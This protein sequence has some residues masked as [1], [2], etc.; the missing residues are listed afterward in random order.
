[1]PATLAQPL[2]RAAQVNGNG[3]ATICGERQRT[4]REVRQ[5]V[6]QLAGALADLGI[7]EGERIG[8]L[9]WNSDRYFELNFAIPWLGA[10]LVPLNTRLETAELDYMLRD[11]GVSALC[12]DANGAA[13]VA[14]LAATSA[15]LRAVIALD[16]NVPA[17]MLDYETLVRNGAPREDGARG[18]DQL[19]G[20]FYT[21]G[22]SGQAKGVML[23]HDNLIA[24][25]S[26]VIPQVGYD[27]NSVYL[28]AA[29]MFHLA[30]GMAIYALTTVGGTHVF[31]PHFDAAACLDLLARHRVTNIALVPTMVEL[32]VREAERAPRDLSALR[33][34]QFGAAPMPDGT[35][36]RLV[37]L[38]PELLL[39]H[40]WGMTEL[41]PVGTML[42][43]HW[44]RPA[45]AGDRLRSCGTAALNLELRIV[46]PDGR[47]LPPGEVGEI[48][49]RGPVVMLGYWNKPEETAAALRDGWLHTG[50]LAWLD[51]E[52]LVYIVDRLKDM[53]ITGGEN[54]FSSE[55][56]NVLSQQPGVAAVAVIGLPDP[57]YGEAVHAVVV[58]EP[59]ATLDGAAL[60]AACRGHI[61]GYKCPR[62]VTIRTEP[63][64]LS[65]TGKILKRVLREQYRPSP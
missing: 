53:I 25:A 9:A 38:W 14:P 55:V 4:W 35:L 42:P 50:D 59:G 64:P 39:L 3:I 56:E 30:D 45:V 12:V 31:M 63:L 1:M 27:G 60:I 2:H 13:R 15:G 10:V 43:W 62:S 7:R 41:A 33:Q 11:A 26:N 6:M 51:D 20:I 48:V 47:E 28:H 61:A 22:N 44:R 5:R 49:M 29:P 23:S 65:G 58:P 34:I 54:V 32:I 19:A 24:N 8:L 16:D 40:G 57:T 21:S 52:G 17:G 37:R 36:Q 46:D 18:G